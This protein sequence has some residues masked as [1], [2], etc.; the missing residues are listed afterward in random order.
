ML[1]N[2]IRYL[3]LGVGYRP[4]RSVFGGT[5]L[6]EVSV[7]KSD[8]IPWMLKKARRVPFAFQSDRENF[9][10]DIHAYL[11]MVEDSR[12]AMFYDMVAL[13]MMAKFTDIFYTDN[14]IGGVNNQPASV[15]ANDLMI[16]KLTPSWKEN[17]EV[18]VAIAKQAESATWHSLGMDE[19][20]LPIIY[21][22]LGRF[23][24]EYP[25]LEGLIPV[26]CSAMNAAENMANLIEGRT[27]GNLPA[28][29][30]AN[31]VQFLFNYSM[32]VM[33]ASMAWEGFLKPKGQEVISEVRMAMQPKL[34]GTASEAFDF[35]D[36]IKRLF[37]KGFRAS[38]VQERYAENLLYG[39][40]GHTALLPGD[41]RGPFIYGW[42]TNYTM[43]QELADAGY[44]AIFS[45]GGRGR[46]LIGGHYYN[47]EE[48]F[49]WLLRHNYKPGT[50]I[51][52]YACFF[53]SDAAEMK[54][55]ANLAGATVK[56]PR[57]TIGFRPESGFYT[58]AETDNTWIAN[59]EG[60]RVRY[61]Q[62]SE[63]PAQFATA[64]PDEISRV[65]LTEFNRGLTELL[66]RPADD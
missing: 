59:Q 12:G 36:M 57:T 20:G 61:T 6:P 10:K 26:Y 2:L 58:I 37:L 22:Y 19:S 41:K 21:D 17:N 65:K 5:R 14:L 8:P 23:H 31:S 27:G 15:R 4:A 47:A 62:G 60:V 42:Y 44:V 46:L 1:D 50:P 66:P 54:K 38:P 35:K 13:Y 45:H 63:V 7:T 52:M 48:I 24:W 32:A 33:D 16:A 11:D 25:F 40:D 53:G 29:K 55:L 43:P 51:I 30:V 34:P 9:A 49:A 28:G 64:E 18:A 3:V 56:A 39:G